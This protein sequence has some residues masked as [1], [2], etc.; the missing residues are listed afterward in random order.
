MKNKTLSWL[1]SKSST[2]QSK[3]IPFSTKRACRM[4][5]IQHQREETL[6]RVQ[7]E[8]HKEK[9]QKIDQRERKKVEKKMASV[10]Q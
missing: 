3:I 10:I 1:S 8:R 9:H 6:K 4:K 7:D 5:L 2:E